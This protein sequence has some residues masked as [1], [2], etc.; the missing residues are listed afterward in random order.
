TADYTIVAQHADLAG[1]AAAL[2]I[3]RAF[4]SGCAAL[5]GVEA[6]SNGVP[7]FRKPKSRNAAITLL[8]MGLLSITMFSGLIFLALRSGVKL[9]QPSHI[10]HN[11]LINGVPAGPEYYQQPII[12]QVAAAVFACGSPAF[13]VFSAVTTLILFLAAH[14]AFY[15]FPVLAPLLAQSRYMPRQLHPRGDRLAFSNGI[16]LLAAGAITL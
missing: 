15:G 7:A 5:T 12:A 4:A 1:L 16:L 3:L 13:L 14:T 11:V 9:T 8:M 2:V 6:I 10:A